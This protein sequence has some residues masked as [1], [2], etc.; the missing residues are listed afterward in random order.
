MKIAV[1]SDVHIGRKDALVEEF[2]NSMRAIGNKVDII[3]IAGDIVDN[4]K[5]TTREKFNDFLTISKDEGFFEKLFFIYGGMKHEVKL[6]HSFPGLLLNDYCLLSTQ[7]GR[8]L[9]LHGNN[10]GLYYNPTIGEHAKVGAER[11]KLNLINHPVSWLPRIH[12]E[13]FLVFGHLHKRFYHE[14]NKR[15]YHEPRK[16][17]CTGCWVPT[18]DEAN[19]TGYVIMIDD[20]DENPFIA[21]NFIYS[22]NS[23]LQSKNF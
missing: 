19:D 23:F 1:T 15:F 5:N 12:Q 22:N 16:I 17:Y 2:F 4:D 3:V 13:D 18:A 7:I 10:I 14:P 11:A 6:L 21:K 8:M 9:I 20:Q